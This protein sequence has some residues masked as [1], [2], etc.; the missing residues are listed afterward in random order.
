MRRNK[1]EARMRCAI[2]ARVSTEDQHCEMQ[3][4]ELRAFAGRMGWAEPI[5]Y[6]ERASSVKRR[7]IFDGLMADARLRQFD[8]VL[9][10]RIDRIARSMKQFVDTVLTLD[11]AGVRFLSPAQNIDTD[12]KNP[13]SRFLMHILAAVAELERNMIV[14]RV[15]AGLQEYKRA[16][17]GGSVGTQRH[18]RSGKDLAVGRPRKVFRRDQVRD[19]RAKGWSWRRIA[20]RLR[21]PFSTVR[22]AI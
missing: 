3:L 14:D 22:R 9:V 1:S 17:A 12:A 16:Y 6:V 8:V 15:N 10:W 19:L 20:D 2:Y 13:T 4:T 7:P 18:S 11:G 21:I 5:E